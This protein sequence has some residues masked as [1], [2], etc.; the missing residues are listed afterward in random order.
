MGVGIDDLQCVISFSFKVGRKLE[1]EVGNCPRRV[2]TQH[3][4]VAAVVQWMKLLLRTL[5][6]HL[7]M[8]GIKSSFRF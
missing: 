8:P 1:E 2:K 6:S 3:L 5:A 7:R 4:G